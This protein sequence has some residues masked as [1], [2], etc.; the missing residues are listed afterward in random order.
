[1]RVL[2]VDPGS[3][4]VGLAMSD[5]SGTIATPLTT[6]G[7]EPADS[8]AVRV[9]AI[10]AEHEVGRILV[11]LPRELDGGR[12]PAAAAAQRLATALRAASRLPVEMF[13]ERLTTAAAERAM[14]ETGTRRATRRKAIDQVAAA[15]LLQ[16]Y[17]DLKRSRH[18]G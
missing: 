17:L 5:P 1:M 15:M 12:G 6:I 11:G 3:K 16:T 8:L 9:A 13:D 10:A 2:A 7:A 18:A 14:I 4:R